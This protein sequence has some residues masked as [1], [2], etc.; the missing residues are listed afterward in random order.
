MRN[1]KSA[2]NFIWKPEGKGLF[3]K[4]K[5][6]WEDNINMNLTGLVCEGVGWTQLL[7]HGVQ[8]WNFVNTAMNIRV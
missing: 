1:E 4:S 7:Q 6:S 5:R 3:G 8:Q 2:Q